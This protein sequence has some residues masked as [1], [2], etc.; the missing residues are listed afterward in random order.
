MTAQW[1]ELPNAL[2]ATAS[3]RIINEARG[4]NRAVSDISGKP[5]AMI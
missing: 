4:F 3:K 5:P 1:E 2:L